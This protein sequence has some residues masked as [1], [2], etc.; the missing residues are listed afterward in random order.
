MLLILSIF[1]SILAVKA[2]F[3]KNLKLLN[4]NNTQCY[5]DY[6]KY[7]KPTHNKNELDVSFIDYLE[8]W[9]DSVETEEELLL[10]TCRIIEI[11]KIKQ[12]TKN[13][14]LI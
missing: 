4:F 10:K 7:A 8:Y 2:S 13:K 14:M 1:I 12:L 5:K 11:K 9:W 3:E 6:F